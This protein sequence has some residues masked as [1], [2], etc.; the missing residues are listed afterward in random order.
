MRVL[1]LPFLV[2][3]SLLGCTAYPLDANQRNAFETLGLQPTCSIDDVNKMFYSI[4]VNS[5]LSG[6]NSTQRVRNAGAARDT[7]NKYLERKRLLQFSPKA[8]KLFSK[9]SAVWDTV[10]ESDRTALQSLFREYFKSPHSNVLGQDLTVTLPFFFSDEQILPFLGFLNFLVYAVVFGSIFAGV[11]VCASFYLCYCIIRAVLQFLWSAIAFVWKGTAAV[12]PKLLLPQPSSESA[13]VSVPTSA[14]IPDTIPT[15]TH[16]PTPSEG[17]T[18]SEEDASAVKNDPCNT[19]ETS[20]SADTSSG[21]SDTS[22]GTGRR[23]SPLSV[24]LSHLL[25]S[26]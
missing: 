18:T 10:P 8:E 5:A 11:G 24:E 7:A 19:T 15:H 6:H 12:L 3:V 22:S 9:A 17:P 14:A 20:A 4:V 2:V 1:F 21:G 16:L 23:D 26:E 25:D 13:S